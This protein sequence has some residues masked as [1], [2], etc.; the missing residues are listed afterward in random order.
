[1][2][3]KIKGLFIQSYQILVYDDFLNFLFPPKIVYDKCNAC[4]TSKLK[5]LVRSALSIFMT[6]LFHIFVISLVTIFYRCKKET[7]LRK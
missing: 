1:M 7:N 6:H 3:R 5:S 2:T 4:H